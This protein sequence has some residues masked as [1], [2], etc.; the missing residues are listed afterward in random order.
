[1]RSERS[2]LGQILGLEPAAGLNATESREINAVIQKVAEQGVTVALIEHDV[3]M[4]MG[5]SNHI[6]ALDYGR[7]LT[8]GTPAEIAAHNV[9]HVPDP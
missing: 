9:R 1:M 5:I 4:V 8:E 2:L 6:L 3:K 7:K